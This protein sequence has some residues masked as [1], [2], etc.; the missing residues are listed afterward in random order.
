MSQERI[1]QALFSLPKMASR[2]RVGKGRDFKKNVNY[3]VF[4]C[5]QKQ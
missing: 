1:G 3:E 5:L 4:F 2:K